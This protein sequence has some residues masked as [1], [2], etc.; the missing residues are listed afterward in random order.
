M[1]TRLIAGLAALTVAVAG[2]VLATANGQTK[3]SCPLNLTARFAEVQRNSGNPPFSGTN[4]SA[5]TLDGTLCGKPFHGAARD[6]NH[7]PTLGKFNG[8]VV[9]F[10]PLGSIKANFAGTATEHPDHSA[11]LDGK[12]TITGGTGLYKH[13]SGTNSLTGTQPANTPVTTQHLSGTLNY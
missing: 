12:A 10:G 9:T 13:A 4:T 3:H 7:F 6:V 2:A 8:T 11:T 5:A 1:R